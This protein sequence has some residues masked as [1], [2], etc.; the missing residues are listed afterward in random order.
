MSRNFCSCRAVAF[1]FRPWILVEAGGRDHTEHLAV[2]PKIT[3]CDGA[4]SVPNRPLRGR[5][6]VVSLCL[7]LIRCSL[8]SS[9]GSLFTSSQQMPE[10]VVIPGYVTISAS[11]ISSTAVKGT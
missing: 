2:L 4:Q 5:T 6:A 9:V 10:R 7:P 8:I 1:V 3:H 11:V